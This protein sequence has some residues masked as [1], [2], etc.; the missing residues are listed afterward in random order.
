MERRARTGARSNRAHRAVCAESQGSMRPGDVYKV[1]RHFVAIPQCDRYRRGWFLTFTLWTTTEIW[2]Q[3]VV[4]RDILI[5]FK[6]EPDLQA[7]FKI[8]L[9]INFT[10]DLGSNRL[11][12]CLSE[13]NLVDN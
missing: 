9:P 11:S 7:D 12:T 10:N 2:V 1:F 8:F 4:S 6:D 5:L 3:E 13:G